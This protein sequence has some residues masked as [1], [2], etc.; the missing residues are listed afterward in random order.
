MLDNS[1]DLRQLALEISM[2]FDV[3]S[4]S[5]YA[6]EEAV[7]QKCKEEVCD[8]CKEILNELLGSMTIIKPQLHALA[9]VFQFFNFD[10]AA[11]AAIAIEKLEYQLH[12]P[13]GE[14][15]AAEKN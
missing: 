10:Q 6:F 13:F 15:P 8:D 5:C 3:L 11:L 14:H 1:P 4:V 7:I 2:S 9:R 12:E